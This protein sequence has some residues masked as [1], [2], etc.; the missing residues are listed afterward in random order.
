MKKRF[1]LS[2][3]LLAFG[4]SIAQTTTT[5]TNLDFT[6][7]HTISPYLFGYNQ[8]HQ[9]HDDDE[10]WSIRRLGGNR[11]TGFNWE[12]GAS[13]SGH[14]NPDYTNDNRIP[15]LVGVN[16][17]DKPGEAYRYFHQ[18]NLDGN[19]ESIITVPILGWVAADKN[20]SNK[21]FPPSNRWNDIVFKKN[22]PFTLT[23]DLTDGKVY[24]DESIN[25]LI[26]KFGN[27]KSVNGVKYIALDNEP[28]LWDATHDYLQPSPPSIKEYV[29]K[30]IEASKAVKAVDPN[31]KII[32]GEF[33]GINIYDFGNAPD[34]SDIKTQGYKWFPDYFLDTLK[35]ASDKEG[36]PLIDLISFHNYPQQKVDAT[37]KFSNA[38]VVIRHSNSNADYVRK[39]R[40]DFPRSLW[41]DSYIEPSWLTG[42]KLKNESHKLLVRLQESIDTYFPNTKIM[43]GEYD[44]GNDTDISHGL[45][46]ADFLGVVAQQNVEIVTRWDLQT[47]SN[48]YT[49][50]AYKLFRNYDG[51]K[52]TIGSVCVNSTFDNIDNSSVWASEDTDDDDLHLILINKNLK[53]STHFIVKFNTTE[54][55]KH[56]FKELYLFDQSSTALSTRDAS[57]I[58]T[59]NNK[60]VKCT[61]PPLTAYHLVLKRDKIITD[62]TTKIQSS[63][64]VFPNLVEN[65]ITMDF[66]ENVTGN[67]QMVSIDGKIIQSHYFENTKQKVLNTQD[68]S[69]GQYILKIQT[70]YSSHQELILKP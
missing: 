52:S 6:K 23:P 44:Y 50:S 30:I 33:A 8:D 38:G 57:Q 15:S 4:A 2:A 40:M 37:G 48:P 62:F 31:I 24:V 29:G 11:L 20:G 39:A 47:L 1:L 60:K 22:A 66:N 59:L 19:V 35:K 14:D 12:N 21:T 26:N 27:A 55:S 28:A 43:I 17:K 45:A 54:Y 13:N 69:K 16:D 67:I 42:A 63:I 7:K 25:F 18:S 3:A 70:Q 5:I 51:Q 46:I 36:Y 56:H 65:H 53:D 9:K 68:L 32:A 64:K 34:W 58:S 49:S 61:I 10:N 41:D